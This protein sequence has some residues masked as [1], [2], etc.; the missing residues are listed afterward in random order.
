MKCWRF[1]RRRQESRSTSRISN[2]GHSPAT[3]NVATTTTAAISNDNILNTNSSNSGNGDEYIR[4]GGERAPSVSS[5]SVTSGG[6]NIDISLFD[7]LEEI[8]ASIRL[9]AATSPIDSLSPELRR[10]YVSNVLIIKVRIGIWRKPPVHVSIDF[11]AHVLKTLIVRC[12]FPFLSNYIWLG[13]SN[14]NLNKCGR[15][16]FPSLT[17]N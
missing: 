7:D 9:T 3:S 12:G 16:R 6:D 4:G 14:M 13:L 15:E 17:E 1:Q 5:S 8:L 2:G 10:E 11:L